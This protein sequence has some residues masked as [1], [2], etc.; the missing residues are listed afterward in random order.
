MQFSYNNC[1]NT[2]LSAPYFYCLYALRCV[3]KQPCTSAPQTSPP[4][5]ALS[6]TIRSSTGTWS[7]RSE[8]QLLKVLLTALTGSQEP[9]SERNACRRRRKE[10]GPV[11]LYV[12][13]QLVHIVGAAVFPP[14]V[15]GHRGPSALDCYC[16]RLTAKLDS[17]DIPVL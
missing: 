12:L 16:K 5:S 9:Q 17:T 13:T 2:P 7:H 8:T 1:F 11:A 10:A 14:G 4:S 6:E 3:L 15:R